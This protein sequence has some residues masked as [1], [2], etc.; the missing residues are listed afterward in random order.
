M[1]HYGR[2]AVLLISI[3]KIVYMKKLILAGWAAISFFTGFSQNNSK[4]S[5]QVPAFHG[6]E[7]SG[8]VDL[9]ISS[10]SSMVAVSAANDNIRHHL[11]T[12]VVDGILRIHPQED[13]QP[14][15][16]NPKMKAYVSLPDLDRLL[17][18]GGGNIFIQGTI[19]VSGLELTLSG[20]GNLEGKLNAGH[21]N[22]NQSGGSNVKLT[23][24]V[25]DLQVNARGGGKLEGYDLVTDYAS[26]HASG[27]SNSELT[28]NKELRVMASGGSDVYYK[29]PASVKEIKSSG[30]G[31]VTHKD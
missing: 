10:G 12:E 26:I 28:V 16:P 18:S 1:Q 8:G 22:I 11:V 21:L 15:V 14:D 24:S 9:Y 19:S 6:V 20:G 3:Q 7:V 2:S 23:G 27:G 29:G 25:K 17:A 31:S 13:W 5:R 4:E 30:G